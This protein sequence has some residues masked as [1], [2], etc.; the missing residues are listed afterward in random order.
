M[1]IGTDPEDISPFANSFITDRALIWENVVAIFQG[2]DAWTYLNT[3]KKHR[4]VRLGL[5]L[6]YTHYLGPSN[7]YHMAA[8]AEKKLAQF[9]YT[10]EKRNWA[11]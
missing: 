11:F 9:S 6:I 2:S 10:G 7:I 8:G 3:L 5:R 4:D 1:V